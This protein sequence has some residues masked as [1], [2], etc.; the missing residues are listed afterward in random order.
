MNVLLHKRINS[1]LSVI[2]SSVSIKLQIKK[3]RKSFQGQKLDQ[4]SHWE[5]EW[6]NFVFSSM[7]SQEI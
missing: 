5:K 4:I 2:L 6:D 1:R 3:K 7:D